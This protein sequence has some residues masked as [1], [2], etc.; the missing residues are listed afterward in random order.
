MAQ[1]R[2]SANPTKVLP[3]LDEELPLMATQIEKISQREFARRDGCDPKLVRIAIDDGHLAPLPGGGLDAA[4][5]GTG[6]RRTNRRGGEKVGK[7]RSKVG[8]VPTKARTLPT[9]RSEP[10]PS[11]ALPLPDVV[12]TLSAM[13]D[14][15]ASDASVV[16]L[17]HLPLA[18]VRPMVAELLA[19]ARR[20]ATEILD[21]DGIDPPMGLTRW[22]EHP[23]FSSTVPTEDEWVEA[24]Q[25]AEAGDA[26]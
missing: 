3:T 6:W 9:R 11:S 12:C 25:L 14:S 4:L 7:V 26:I 5:V 18:T 15:F 20:E 1:T 13:V 21:D 10:A 2:S 16:L 23:A 24:L 17:R 8:S 22:A 19:S